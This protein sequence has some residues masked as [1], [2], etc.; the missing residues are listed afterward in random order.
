[1]TILLW[2][3]LVGQGKSAVPDGFKLARLLELRKDEIVFWL[4]ADQCEVSMP[5]NGR[6]DSEFP[7]ACCYAVRV[8]EEVVA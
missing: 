8:A 1:M 5:R 7:E 3:A 6:R 4:V 2:R